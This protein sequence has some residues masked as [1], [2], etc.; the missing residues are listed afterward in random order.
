[1][2][3][4]LLLAC[5]LCLPGV[6]AETRPL[7]RDF[8]GINGHFTFKPQLYRPL[9]RL[10]RNYHN[11]DWDVKRPGDPITVPHCVNKVDWV[12]NLYGPWNAAGFETD[13]CLQFNVFAKDGYQ[14]LWSGQEGWCHDYG[15]AVAS[16]FADQ[17]GCRLATSYEIGN[18]PGQRFDAA[19]YRRLFIAMA[20]GIRAGDPK[21]LI[22][23][24]TARA[25]QADDYSQ[26]LRA[27]YEGK[28]ILPLFD[29]INV[30]T[31]AEAPRTKTTC[32]WTRS[33]PEDPGLDY[34]QVVDEAIAWRDG[35]AKGKQVW[36]TEF[37]YDACTPAAMAR[38]SGWFQKL[39]WQGVDDLQQA[40]YLVR[41]Y[42]AFAE[43]DV[44]RAY[45]YYYDDK[46]EPSVHACAGVTRNFQPKPSY[47]AVRQLQDVLGDCRFAKVV[48]QEPGKLRVQEY[49][50]GPEARGTVVWVAWSPTGC[51]TDAKAGYQPAHATV[52]LSGLPGRPEAIAMATADGK[53]APVEAQVS[54][55]AV[56]LEVGESPV[57]LVMH[58]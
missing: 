5:L 40:Q 24:A 27:I 6:A 7:F 16:C 31:Y 33:Y 54:A 37:G 12:A 38:R 41:S 56:T 13:V 43:R 29:V 28:D 9:C 52:T 26:D 50:G 35:K 25:R 51:R 42:L 1:M 23:T 20:G 11:I 15:A 8:M 30:H 34:L 57:Y 10:V 36:V 32:P 49:V 14:A 22:A 47:W 3:F 55:R 18:E 2:G 17:G 58:R 19:T 45:L 48:R 39:D 4:R 44:R 46:D 21:A 53:P